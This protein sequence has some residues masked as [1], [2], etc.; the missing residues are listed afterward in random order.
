MK[1]R[2]E[3]SILIENIKEHLNTSSHFYLTDISGLN[4]EETSALR[5]KCFENGI[6]V[7]VVKNKL[8]KLAFESIEKDY[9]EL[10]DILKGNTTIMFSEKGNIPAKIIKEIRKA[11][12]E[13]PLLKGA[14][15][16]EGIYIGDDQLEIL[17][18]IKSKEELIGD[19]ILLLQSPMKNVISSIKSGQDILAGIVKTLSD[20][21]E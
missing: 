4:A 17:A 16:E 13:K 14:F 15:V 12:K 18:S 11:G 5:R 10:Y 7:L 19:I 8:L 2:E 3:K 6:K 1:S 20:K 9:N 21:K